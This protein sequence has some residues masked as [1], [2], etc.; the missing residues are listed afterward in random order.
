MAQ[1]IVVPVDAAEDTAR[2]AGS[3]ARGG[4]LRAVAG[5]PLAL[6]RSAASFATGGL[7][8]GSNPNT[9]RAA[10]AHPGAERATHVPARAPWGVHCSMLKI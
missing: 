2:I 4:V 1:Q 6:V 9:P 7:G 3:Q 5:A 10:G 8:G